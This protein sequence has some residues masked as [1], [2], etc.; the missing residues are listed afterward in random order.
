MITT[1]T[2]LITSSSSRLATRP[3]VRPSVLVCSTQLFFFTD[4]L[5]QNMC[6]SLSQLLS[7]A[8]SL[9]SACL[10]EV[11]CLAV[12]RN[13]RQRQKKKKK[14]K[15]GQKC[16]LTMC[17]NSLTH[18]VKSAVLDE[19]AAEDTHTHFLLLRKSAGGKCPDD[20]VLLLLLLLS[21]STLKWP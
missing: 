13:R 19:A 21:S 11:I 16:L 18:S 3:S 9:Y 20:E 10:S 17:Y 12:S 1:I 7:E 2:T 15:N 5:S 8:V 6:F 14:K 4:S